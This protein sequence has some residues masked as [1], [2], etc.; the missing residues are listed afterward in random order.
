MRHKGIGIFIT[1]NKWLRSEYGTKLRT[2]FIEKMNPECLIDLGS[3]IFPNA[4]VDTNILLWK[5]ETYNGETLYCSLKRGLR[6]I[7]EGL[8]LKSQA[9]SKDNIWNVLSTDELRIKQK[10]ETIKTRLT[11]FNVKLNYGILTGANEAFLLDKKNVEYLCQ[12]DEKNK[13]LIK[14]ILRGKDLFRYSCVFADKYLLNVH[15]GV[16][17]LNIP[18]VN[19]DKYPTLIEYFES[20][21]EKFKKRGEQGDNW[22]NLRNCA[23]IM[24]YETPKILYSDIVQKRGKFYYDEQKYY[25][26]DTAFMII[27][28]HLKYLVAIL[29]SKLFSYLYSNFYSGGVLGDKGLR[30]KKEFLLK[31]PIP[32]A[33][34]A[35]NEKVVHIVDSIL[36]E[37]LINANADTSFSEQEIDRLVYELYDLTPDE[38]EIIER[39]GD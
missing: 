22:Y 20:F 34:V 8:D 37:K 21:G 14:P 26:N 12:L 29:N 13:E 16:K 25:T 30:Y 4:T 11:D 1:S 31:V 38:I 15:N 10:V 28:D 23:Y 3:N 5:K 24:D 2:Y 7:E 6:S 33:S 19:L 39:Q 36:A 35:L 18:P 27:G 17:R 9:L 32:F